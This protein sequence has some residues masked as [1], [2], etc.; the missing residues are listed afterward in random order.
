LYESKKSK[1]G[2]QFGVGGHYR[3]ASEAKG[4]LGLK[5]MNTEMLQKMTDELFSKY[6]SELKSNGFE[7]V[8]A[9]KINHPDAT[10][11]CSGWGD[12]ATNFLT[13]CG[14][15]LFR[16]ENVGIIIGS[17]TASTL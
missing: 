3:G 9:E 2:G 5:D 8:S 13:Q 1:A 11:S 14:I 4:A 12:G 10:S 17:C 16:N 15:L 6:I 7:I